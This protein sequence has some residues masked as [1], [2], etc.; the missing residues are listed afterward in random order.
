M[1]IYFLI[2]VPNGR[3]TSDP[4]PHHHVVIQQQKQLK[5]PTQQLQQQLLLTDEERELLQQQIRQNR[6]HSILD[7]Y[8]IDR[9]IR[10]G[11]FIKYC[12]FSL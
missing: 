8:R 1:Y 2:S 5:Q 6:R 4:I 3:R 7:S 10:Y 9:N 12:V 11:V